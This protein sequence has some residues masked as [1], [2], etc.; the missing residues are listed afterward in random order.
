MAGG[1]SGAVVPEAAAKRVFQFKVEVPPLVKRST[2][3]SK[4][5]LALETAVAMPSGELAAAAPVDNGTS[6]AA[7]AAG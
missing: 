7:P 6:G 1:A 5:S 4:L 3:A 2:T